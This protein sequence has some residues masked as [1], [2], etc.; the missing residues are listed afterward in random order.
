MEQLVNL[1]YSV[2]LVTNENS[3]KPT[4]EHK[5]HKAL[6]RL[7]TNPRHRKLETSGSTSDCTKPLGTLHGIRNCLVTGHRNPCTLSDLT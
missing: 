4:M 3:E 1:E 6:N 5:N 7:N 2:A